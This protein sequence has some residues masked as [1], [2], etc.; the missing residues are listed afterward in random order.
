MFKGE[1]ILS[2]EHNVQEDVTT[3]HNADDTADQ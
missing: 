2:E 3:H 1:E